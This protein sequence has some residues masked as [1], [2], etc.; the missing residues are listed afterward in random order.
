M[1][2]NQDLRL[3]AKGEHGRDVILEWSLPDAASRR[4]YI[5][6]LWFVHEGYGNLQTR[7]FQVSKDSIGIVLQ[8][9]ASRIGSLIW[10]KWTSG[11]GESC[12]S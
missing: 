6:F 5:S 2:E 12:L 10:L 3:Q 4:S 8:R 7:E 9:M 1:A 11:H